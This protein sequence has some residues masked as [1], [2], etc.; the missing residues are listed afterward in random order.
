[1]QPQP[2]TNVSAAR[3]I[4]PASDRAMGKYRLTC[5]VIGSLGR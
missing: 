5:K 2:G 3:T 4:F 1:M